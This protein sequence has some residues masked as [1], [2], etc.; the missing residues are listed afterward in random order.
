MTAALQDYVGNLNTY[1]NLHGNINTYAN[2]HA[3][4]VFDLM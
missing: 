3:C 2:M 4:D 1:A